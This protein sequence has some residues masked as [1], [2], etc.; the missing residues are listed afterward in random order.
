M[1]IIKLHIVF[2]LLLQLSLIAQPETFKINTSSEATLLQ[3]LS[4]IN[5]FENLNPDSALF[6]YETLLESLQSYVGESKE[7]FNYRFY[8]AKILNKISFIQMMYKSNFKEVI[9]KSNSAR[10][11]LDILLP[12]ADTEM[13]VELIRAELGINNLNLGKVY[14]RRGYFLNA[15]DY[16]ITANKI[17][18]GLRN[19][20]LKARCL[21]YIGSVNDCIGDYFKAQEYYFQSLGLIEPFGL[22]NTLGEVLYHIGLNYFELDI[23][24][25][26]LYYLNK[27][28]SVF[29]LTSNKHGQAVSMYYM[30]M[31]YSN[32][33]KFYN[34]NKALSYFSQSLSLFKSV[35]DSF[36]IS[37]IYSSLSKLHINLKNYD[38]AENFALNA[39]QIANNLNSIYL[40]CYPYKHLSSIHVCKGDTAKA[41]EYQLI[42][43]MMLDSL[44]GGDNGKICIEAS[45]KESLFNFNKKLLNEKAESQKKIILI[46]IVGIILTIALSIIILIILKKNSDIKNKIKLRDSL[47]EGEEKERQRIGQELHD[48]VC[49]ELSAIKMNLEILKNNYNSN[50]NFDKIINSINETNET[51]RLISHNLNSIIL[52]KFGLLAAVHNLCEK[53]YDIKLFQL[54]TEVAS[55][56]TQPLSDTKAATLYRIIQEIFNNIIKHSKATEVFFKLIQI[57]NKLFILI[58]DNGIGFSSNPNEHKNSL[59]LENIRSRVSL[60][61]GTIN[62]VSNINKGTEIQ[63]EIPFD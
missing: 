62:I 11:L 16:Y 10:N 30:G 20:E 49:S 26:A 44:Y 55:E 46:L 12:E 40:K 15:I 45:V 7:S 22:S 23:Q 56:I 34:S 6:N 58:K 37:D 8:Y 57:D 3:T 47:L 61:N 48:G 52:V 29:L 42:Y 19:N 32:E 36:Y 9:Q 33:E 24:D 60:L 17:F 18:E 25:S 54:K 59:G 63:I 27:S 51:I 2:C 1:K 5:T 50:G 43:K 13:R 53:F 38:I 31:A 28:K 41:F 4:Q 39:L 14:E 35:G 21:L